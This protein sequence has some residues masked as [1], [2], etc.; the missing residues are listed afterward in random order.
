MMVMLNWQRMARI[1]TGIALLAAGTAML[2]LPGP[3]LL[4]VA[5]GLAVLGRDAGW[6][7]RISEWLRSCTW[8]PGAPSVAQ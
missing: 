1:G 7:A 6:A 4:T 2:V 3:G 5:G 8:S